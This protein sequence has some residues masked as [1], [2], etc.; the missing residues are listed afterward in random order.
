[1]RKTVKQ[2]EAELAKMKEKLDRRGTGRPRWK[3]Y[4][5]CGQ[6]PDTPRSRTKYPRHK[7]FV[8]NKSAESGIV[9]DVN[10][11]YG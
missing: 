4:C 6:Y 10:S 9:L 5:A 8:E 7:C 2:L 11:V 3:P 1:M